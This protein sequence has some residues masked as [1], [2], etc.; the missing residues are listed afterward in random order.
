[1]APDDAI[2]RE[3]SGASASTSIFSEKVNR[4]AAEA[5]LPLLSS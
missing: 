3:C 2:F 1:M 5:Y 4:A